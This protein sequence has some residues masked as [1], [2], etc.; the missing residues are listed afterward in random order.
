MIRMMIVMKGEK[1][2]QLPLNNK[3]GE[4]GKQERE[5]ERN[6]KLIKRM[7]NK[8]FGMIQLLSLSFEYNDDD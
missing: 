3:S 8:L 5:R 1:G 6:K 7:Q 2:K 4:K